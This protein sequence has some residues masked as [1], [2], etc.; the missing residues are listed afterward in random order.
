M[1]EYRNK[2][3]DVS[4]NG[5]IDRF[6]KVLPKKSV[7]IVAMAR[8]FNCSVEEVPMPAGMSGAIVKEDS[9]KYQIFVNETESNERKRFTIA[10]ELAHCLL[11]KKALGDGISENI[12]FRGKLSNIFETEANK[13]AADIL[14]PENRLNELIETRKYGFNEL[15][16]IFGVSRAAILV[17]LGIPEHPDYH[18][19]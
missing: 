14:M 12:M 10:H 7:D 2:K 15:A 3:L 9:S 11:H 8:E 19:C 4:Q 18:A 5:I 1:N 17:R 13:V 6:Q 16:T